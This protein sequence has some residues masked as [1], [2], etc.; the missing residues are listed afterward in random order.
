MASSK[1]ATA[2]P[3]GSQKPAE[4]GTIYEARVTLSTINIDTM[5]WDNY[6]SCLDTPNAIKAAIVALGLTDAQ[7]ATLWVRPQIGGKYMYSDRTW[8]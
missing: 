7:L 2:A 5:K 6:G 1:R 3:R 8:R 4:L